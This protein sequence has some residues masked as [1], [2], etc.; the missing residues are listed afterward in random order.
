MYHYL[1]ILVYLK[2]MT[3][4]YTYANAISNIVEDY[5]ELEFEPYDKE[6]NF[7]NVDPNSIT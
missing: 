7:Y 4:I 5:T 6:I 3:F 1:I 2:I